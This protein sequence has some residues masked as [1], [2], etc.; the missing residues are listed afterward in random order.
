MS[1]PREKNNNAT[2]LDQLKQGF[3]YKTDVEIARF[4]GVTKETISQIRRGELG[5]SL[6][7]RIKIMDRLSSI[8][9]RDLLERIT[10]ENLSN[11]LHRLSLRGAERLALDELEKGEP[12]AVDIK[13]IE[14]FKTY[15]QDE[16]LFITDKEMATFLGLKRA[17]ISGVRT[18]KSK[19]GPLPRLRILKLICPELDL[20]Q[21]EKGIESS[22]YLLKLIEEH[23]KLQNSNSNG[24]FGAR[25]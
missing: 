20:E 8:Q 10:P 5:L 25:E 1:I 2:L 11:E 18:G 21:I 14:L 7:Q 19:L 3:G 16:N 22:Q 12:T 24:G 17:T 15:G 13:L 6:S 9:I 23:I 4:L